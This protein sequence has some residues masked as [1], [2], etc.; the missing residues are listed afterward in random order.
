MLPSSVSSKFS[1]LYEEYEARET[2]ESQV[3]KELDRFDVMLQAFQ[4][5]REKW[6]STKE[7]VRYDEFFEA[8]QRNVH[9]PKL[10]KMLDRIT[11]ERDR[12][13]MEVS[14]VRGD[15]QSKIPDSQEKK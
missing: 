9:H 10:R 15:S 4:Y 1:K 8:A 14:S 2:P 11:Q 7:V 6:N 13:L 3:V 12:F 5:E